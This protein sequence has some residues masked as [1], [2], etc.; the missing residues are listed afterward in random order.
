MNTNLR[1]GIVAAT[2]VIAGALL[3]IKQ[4][5][6]RH[7]ANGPGADRSPLADP[8]GS[9]GVSVTSPPAPASRTA[10]VENKPLPRLL[11]LGANKCIPCK[12]M[13]PILADLQKE[14]AGRLEVVFVDI[15]E[16]P[17]MAK[18]YS[19]EVIPTQIFYDAEGNELFRHTG[20]FAK[21]DILAKWKELGVNLK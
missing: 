7:A 21:D 13:M 3:A 15:L 4:I 8:P 2:V 11:D 12:M 9:G 20:F 16:L 1:I 10:A 6:R 14:Y 19:V 17:D 5:D 18:A